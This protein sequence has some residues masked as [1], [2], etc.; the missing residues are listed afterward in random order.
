MAKIAV[1]LRLDPQKLAKLDKYAKARGA[2]RQVLLEAAVDDFLESAERG[3]PDLPVV[4]TPEVRQQRVAVPP[5][6][7]PSLL[8]MRQRRLNKE[9]GW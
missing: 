8:G 2:S 1:A 9:M 4:D 3:V 7:E 5:A 6:P